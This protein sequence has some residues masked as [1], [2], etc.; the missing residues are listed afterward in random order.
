MSTEEKIKKIILNRIEVEFIYIFGSYASGLQNSQSDIDIA[1]YSKKAYSSYDIFILAQKL[2][3]ELGR[4][5]DLVQMK[6]SSTVFQK[7][8][9]SKGKIIFE[10]NRLEREKIE[11]L[12]LKKYIKLNEERKKIIDSYEV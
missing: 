9:I 8:I 7:E 10:K 5:I 2:S 1:F 6:E 12:I 11:N 4:E 3:S